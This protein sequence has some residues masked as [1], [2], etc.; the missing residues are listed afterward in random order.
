MFL[1][2]Y[3]F[4]DPLAKLMGSWASE[5]NIYS[6]AL[7]ILLAFILAGTIG[8][9]RARK[10]HSAGLRTFILVSLASTMAMIVDILCGMTGLFRGF[11]IISAATVSSILSP[12]ESFSPSEQCLHLPVQA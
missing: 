9:E 8:I 7:R 3:A 5:L 11:V 2:E 10:R 6:V 4:I 12:Q 1:E